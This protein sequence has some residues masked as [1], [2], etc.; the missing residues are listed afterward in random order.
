MISEA[1][2]PLVAPPF[3]ECKEVQSLLRLKMVT[4]MPESILVLKR[5]LILSIENQ[6]D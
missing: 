5:T 4:E 6:N 2:L 1:I 3:D